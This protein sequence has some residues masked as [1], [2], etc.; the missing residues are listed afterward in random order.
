[1]Q[2]VLL[3]GLRALGDMVLTMPAVQSIHDTCPDSR[4][5]YL[6]EKPFAAL[7]S[8]EPLIRRVLVLPRNAQSFSGDAGSVKKTYLRFLKE[9]RAERYDIVF[10]LFSRGPRSRVIV[11]ASNAKRRVGIMDH[12]LPFLDSW[13]YTDRVRL[14]NALTHMFDQ[15]QFLTSRLGFRTTRTEPVLTVHPENVLKARSLMGSFPPEGSEGFLA[16]LPGSGMVNKNWPSERFV[17]LIRCVVKRNVAVLVLGGPND[18]RA[19][20][21]VAREFS[22]EEPLFRWIVQSDLP[23]M[24]GIFSMSRG[25]LGNDSGPLHLAQAIGKKV[26]ALFGPGDHVSYRPFH[27]TLVRK[28]LACSPC[29]SFA[30]QCP[31]NWCMKSIGVED[32]LGAL[33]KQEILPP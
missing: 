1:M 20:A 27:G 15:M 30:G 6:M 32:V 23:T 4:I 7:F 16:V 8:E 22:D 21:R 25:V 5:D 14:P 12:P 9:I 29:Q 24:K 11:A 26:V 33:E 31:D 3:V 10:D 19:V 13:I 18:Y 17:E 2:K 28:G